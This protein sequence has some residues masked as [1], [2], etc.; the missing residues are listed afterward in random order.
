M[1]LSAWM[2]VPA[3][4]AAAI[5]S[6]ASASPA[7]AATETVLT[8]FQ[9][10]PSGAAPSGAPVRMNGKLFVLT[11][12]GGTLPTGT[13]ADTCEAGGYG[14]VMRSTAGGGWKVVY[15]FQGGNDGACP[16][17]S[18]TEF[19]GMLYGVTKQGGAADSGTV[20]S[21]DPETGAEAVVYSFKGGTDGLKPFGSLIVAG[22]PIVPGGQLYGTTKYGGTGNASCNTSGLPGCGTVFSLNPASGVETVL[23]SFQGGSDGALPRG[24]LLSFGPILYGT[25]QNGGGIVC[26]TRGGPGCGTVFAVNLA[27]GTETVLHSFGAGGDGRGP[28]GGLTVVG[29]FSVPGSLLYGTAFS[30]G[31]GS[32]PLG[33][34]VVFSVNPRTGDENIVYSFQGGT[35]GYGP[36]GDLTALDGLLYGTVLGGGSASCVPATKTGLTGCGTVYSL[37]PKTGTETVLYTFQG[38]TGGA[39]PADNLNHLGRSLYGATNGGGTANAGTVF[40]ITP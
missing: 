16:T 21:I 7:S 12:T 35:D 30:G 38:G 13:P 27:A 6:L 1:T 20:F 23:H 8:S 28:P 14:T 17:G 31:A 25:T 34:G 39:T 4:A 22:D 18:L 24:R 15:A 9:G 11:V 2:A 26:L 10:A 33:C 29:S 19:R 3:L 40:S 36:G 32:C 37:S 5:A